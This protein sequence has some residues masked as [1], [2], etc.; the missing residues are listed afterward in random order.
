MIVSLAQLGFINVSRKG[1]KAQRK[2]QRGSS[3]SLRL[4]AF[5]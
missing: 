5:A 3:I 2:S 1:A 4:R